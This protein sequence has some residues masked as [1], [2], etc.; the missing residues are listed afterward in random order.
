[1]PPDRNWVINYPTWLVKRFAQ[2]VG[3]NTN[4]ISWVKQL[5]KYFAQLI[6]KTLNQLSW[7]FFY[8]IPVRWHTEP[9]VGYFFAQVGQSF[10]RVYTYIYTRIYITLDGHFGRHGKKWSLWATTSYLNI[11]AY[12]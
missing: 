5:G 4:S 12:S 9:T 3:Q 7:A 6:S 2:L 1:M 10:V 11:F 8:P